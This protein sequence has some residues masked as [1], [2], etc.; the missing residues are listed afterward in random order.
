M[1]KGR[2]CK[3]ALWSQWLITG[4]RSGQPLDWTE[5]RRSPFRP[6][7][8]A[9]SLSRTQNFRR[10]SS[11]T[12]IPLGVNEIVL[13]R[14]DNVGSMVID[15]TGYIPGLAGRLT[16]ILDSINR[17]YLYADNIAIDGNSA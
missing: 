16:P 7:A 12:S 10:P 8:T 1:M 14:T 15:S 4:R 2:P 13:P 5:P 11:S 6:V 3:I 9:A 17:T